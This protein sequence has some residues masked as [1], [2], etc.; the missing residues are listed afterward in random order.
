MLKIKKD[1][2][3]NIKA[4]K[5]RC[6]YTGA[7]LDDEYEQKLD[8]VKEKL[9]K[10]ALKKHDEIKPCGDYCFQI[11]DKKLLFWFNVEGFTTKIISEKLSP[12][13]ISLNK[14]KNI[15]TFQLDYI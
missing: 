14:S 13:L 1:N 7:Q 6:I 8:E 2:E 4:L 5:T 10:K 9:V 3:N 11:Y 15:S 12:H